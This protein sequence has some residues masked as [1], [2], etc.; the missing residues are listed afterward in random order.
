MK[1]VYRLQVLQLRI[2]QA[3]GIQ[4]HLAHE[5]VE[6]GPGGIG[7]VPGIEYLTV[8]RVSGVVPRRQPDE[9]LGHQSP[10][11]WSGGS[12]VDSSQFD[13]VVFRPR[14]VVLD[15]QDERGDEVEGQVH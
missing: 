4:A 15:L 1:E 7:V 6:T 8:R 10:F 9:L 5:E 12:Q 11:L 13:V 3:Q 2:V 14:N